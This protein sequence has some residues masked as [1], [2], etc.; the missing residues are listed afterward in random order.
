M[1]AEHVAPNIIAAAYNE[2]SLPILNWFFEGRRSLPVRHYLD[3]WNG[4]ATAVPIALLLHFILVLLI[5][6]IDHKNRVRLTKGSRVV[7]VNAVLMTFAA[8]F[9]AAT[10]VNSVHADY[11]G[12]LDEWRAVLAGRNPWLHET[13]QR[14][15]NAYGP[16]F[17]A[18][19][20]LVWLNPLANKLLFAFA[21][22]AYM[23]WLLKD[24]APHR[25]AAVLSWP[26]LL[27]WLLNPFPWVEIAYL[28]YSDVLVA[29]A[30]VAAVHS[31]VERKD[32]ASGTCLAL[33]TLLK[34]LPIV[35][36]PFLAFSERRLHAR[37]LVVFLGLVIFG[38]ALSL[39]LW[40]ML[41]FSPL[42]FAAT[43]YPYWS[44]YEVFTPTRFGSLDWLEKPILVIGGLGLFA[45]CQ[46]YRT[47][48]AFSAVL[49]V[50]IT[51]LFYRLG[52]INYH[53]VPFFLIT[54]WLASRWKQFA[55]HS[56]AAVVVA[57]YFGFLAI[58]DILHWSIG[59][60]TV[61]SS[62]IVCKFVLGFAMFIFL[63]TFAMPRT[64]KCPTPEK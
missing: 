36:L 32:G 37:L 20:P 55:R 34:F 59:T 25:G 46:L 12:Y 48:P 4:I 14:A 53:M 30:C 19:A 42:T 64:G 28:G 44:I 17:N 40:G 1:F 39:L 13:P 60:Y 7:C 22:L 16:L 33:G 38:F 6:R 61:G 24:F 43:R 15:F 10:V 27:L 9:L 26:W 63:L 45:W 56:A 29:L 2:Q 11:P 5:K 54:Y 41:T 23:I 51:L 52:Y 3:R 57:V 58:A 21:Y 62:L 8:A 18:L 31:L 47:E 49:A 50:S 35:I